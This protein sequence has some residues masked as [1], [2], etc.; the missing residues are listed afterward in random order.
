LILVII[1]IAASIIYLRVFQFNELV[2]EP[3]I[4]VL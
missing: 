3:K 1:A 2:Q 4:D